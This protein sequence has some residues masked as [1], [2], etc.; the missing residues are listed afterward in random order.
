MIGP[1][2]P[3]PTRAEEKRAYLVVKDRDEGLCQRCRR[4]GTSQED[5]RQ[6]R[7]QGGRT[8]PSNLHLLCHECHLWKTDNGPDAWHDGW[9]VPGW[10]DPA[11]YP[12]RRWLRTPFG[13][14]RQAWVL[15]DDEGS[16]REIGADVALARMGII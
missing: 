6:N 14:L 10:A 8:V 16:F 11:T 3:R 15:Y 7:S 13:T 4:G 2:V 9:G 12:A 5:H 1:K